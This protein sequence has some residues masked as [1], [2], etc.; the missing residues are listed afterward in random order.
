VRADR[1]GASRVRTVTLVHHG[2]SAGYCW[3]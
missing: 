2:G 1:G 3:G